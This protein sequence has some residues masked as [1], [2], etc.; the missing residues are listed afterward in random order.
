M[1]W[2]G[3]MHKSFAIFDMDGTL[4]YSM[5]LWENL[6]QE[7]LESKNITESWD[8]ILEEIRPLTMS[9]SAALFVDRF[10]LA[11]SPETVAD[12]MNGI[13]DVHYRKDISLKPGVKEHLEQLRQAGVRMCVAS[14]TA[15]HLMEACLQRL[16]VRSYFEFLISCESMGTSKREPDIYLEAA[17]RLGAAPGEIAVYEDAL[18]AIETAKKANFH[19]VAV[20]DADAGSHWDQ[21][22]RLA[23]ET[24]TFH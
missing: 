4:I 22:C 13:M 15:E 12:E 6:G 5:K 8:G 23:D 9:Q 24:I 20:Y 11:E 2:Y 3:T 17:S 14:A 18:Y 19:V 10:A 21:I 16:G 1:K 7:C